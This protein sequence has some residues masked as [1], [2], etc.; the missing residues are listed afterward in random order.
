[1]IRG[2]VSPA[3][4]VINRNLARAA[5][6]P[7]WAIRSARGVPPVDYRDRLHV[8]A[9]AGMRTVGSRLSTN[10]RYGYSVKRGAPC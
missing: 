10:K 8:V 3:A 4:H 5:A 2:S 6:S 1:M 7:W 9:I